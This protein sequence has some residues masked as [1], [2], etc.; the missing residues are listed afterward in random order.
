VLSDC[1]QNFVGAVAFRGWTPADTGH[2]EGDGEVSS[3]FA[4]HD[5]AAKWG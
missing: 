1:T 3:Y 5:L 4:D 2:A